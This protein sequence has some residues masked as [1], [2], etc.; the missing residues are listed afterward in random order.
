[1][2]QEGS[3]TAQQCKGYVKALDMSFL[4]QQRG[5]I[6]KYWVKITQRNLNDDL[7]VQRSNSRIML[8][9]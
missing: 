2:T 4:N 1:M 9:A 8:L 3:K 6:K 7:P 5:Q